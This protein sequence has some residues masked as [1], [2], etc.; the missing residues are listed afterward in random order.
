MAGVLNIVLRKRIDTPLDVNIRFGDTSQGAGASR[1]IQGVGGWSADNFDLVYSAEYFHRDP[2][3]GL[4]RNFMDSVA[5]NA[6]QG[7]VGAINPRSLLL[8]DPIDIDGDGFDYIDPG[9][10]ACSPFPEHGLFDAAGARQLLRAAQRSCPGEHPQQ[11]R[12]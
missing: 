9:A 8:S 7:S 6:D 2:I 1:R 11:D 5:D 4:D 3:F 12:S 10:A